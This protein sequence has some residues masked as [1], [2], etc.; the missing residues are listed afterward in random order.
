MGVI[1]KARDLPALE[2]SGM[3]RLVFYCLF[4]K[5]LEEQVVPIK[6]EMAKKLSAM[7]IDG[8]SY[9]AFL[10]LTEFPLLCPFKYRMTKEQLMQDERFTLSTFDATLSVALK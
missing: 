1:I 3:A 7:T 2:R 10:S 5:A 4:D 9:Y 8:S 6:V